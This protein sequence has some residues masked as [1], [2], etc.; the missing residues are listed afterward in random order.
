ML[1]TISKINIRS[2]KGYKDVYLPEHPNADKRGRVLLHRIIMEN[3][4]NRLLKTNE[5]VHHKNG[6]PNDNNI[7]NLELMLSSE[8]TRLHKKINNNL[9][10]L[11]CEFC[12]KEFERSKKNIHNDKHFCCRSHIMKYYGKINKK[13]NKKQIENIQHGTYS[14]YRRGCKCKLCKEVQAKRIYEWRN[15]N[16]MRP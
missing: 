15:K 8:H 16:N 12:G 3:Y 14:R 11:L 13:R 7:N 10:K 1:W 6:D 9:I 5:I 4:I 2:K